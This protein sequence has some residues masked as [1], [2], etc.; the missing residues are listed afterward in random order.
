[1]HYVQGQQV[2][3]H[4]VCTHLITCIDVSR[5]PPTSWFTQTG[6]RVYKTNTERTKTKMIQPT[7]SCSK[8]PLAAYS[9]SAAAWPV[10]LGQP[11]IKRFSI[12]GHSASHLVFVLVVGALVYSDIVVWG[13]VMHD[14]H[15]PGN[16]LTADLYL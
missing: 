15:Q 7:G 2:T 3:T 14:R 1:M 9:A 5:R 11:W 6:A 10:V 16:R 4:G 12:T 13:V 8:E